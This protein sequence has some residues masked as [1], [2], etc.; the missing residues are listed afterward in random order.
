MT[1]DPKKGSLVTILSIDGGGIR[2]IIPATILQFLES[3]LQELDGADARVADYFDIVAGTSTGGLL[4]T[5]ITAPDHNKRPLYAA[6]DIIDFY[7]NQCP[8]FFPGCDRHNVLKTLK[9]LFGPK[10]NGRC[11]RTL[12]KEQLGDTTIKETLTNLVILA[13]DIKRLQ[14]VIFTTKDAKEKAYRDAKLCDICIGT[15]AAPTFLPAHY[16]ETVDE[17]GNTTTYDL[18]D[19]GVAANNPT[20]IA[21]SQISNGILAG[22]SDYAEMSALDGSKVLVLSLGTGIPKQAEKYSAEAA[23]GWGLLGWVYKWGNTPLMD[24]F[25]DASSDM[26]DIHVSTLFQSLHT[27]KNYLRIQDDTLS[28]DQTSLDIATSSNLQEL[29]G[30][31]QRRLKMPMSRVDLE[32]GQFEEVEGEGTNEEALIRFAK[33]L[34]AERK[35]RELGETHTTLVIH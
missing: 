12:L 22:D 32:T 4:A 23:A 17:A 34:S 3:K 5:M 7:L 6:K 9:N 14:P 24:V 33:Q 16:F 26:V 21:I 27:K 29:V 2:G 8:S 28:G 18:I 1:P 11:L 15:S 35:L 13:F 10:Y 20:L 31:A 25:G 30:V 19:G